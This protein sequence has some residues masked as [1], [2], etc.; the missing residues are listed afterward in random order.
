MKELLKKY[1][2]I[3]RYLIIGGLTTVV[4]LVSYY[5]L[6]VTIL[7]PN[8][9]IYLQIA[10][11]ISWILSVTFAYFTNR[12]F[13]FKKKDKANLKEAGSFYAS[14][15]S[16]LLIDMGLMFV[17]VSCMNYPDKI[18]KIIIQVIVVILNYIFS[19]FFVFNRGRNEKKRD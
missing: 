6:T 4:S 7:D 1:E 2:E 18:I 9:S 16:T 14:R 15:V 11:V 8:N 19:K 10:N 12:T 17:L 3:I 13:V 5:I